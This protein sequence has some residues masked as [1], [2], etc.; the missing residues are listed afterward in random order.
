MIKVILF[1]LLTLLSLVSQ[2][3]F[4]HSIK[5]GL[6]TMKDMYPSHAENLPSGFRMAIDQYLPIDQA[7]WSKDLEEL[8]VSLFYELKYERYF[9]ELG[10]DHF[11]LAPS[12]LI[13]NWQ[14]SQNTE[15]L[16]A[17]KVTS[18]FLNFNYGLGYNGGE[19]LQYSLSIG[20]SHIPSFFREPFIYSS[21][22]GAGKSSDAYYDFYK[23]FTEDPF[24]QANSSF[25]SAFALYSRISLS[26]PM[27]DNFRLFTSL[28][29]NSNYSQTLLYHYYERK[30]LG[31]NPVYNLYLNRGAHI[32][33]QIGLAY[34]FENK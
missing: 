10:L 14:T 3:Q 28:K 25:R 32:A 8:S 19:K 21:I 27:S 26:Y 5:L 7:A 12:F 23:D 31:E 11:T 20:A 22:P 29:L 33:L 1:T 6:G 34:N 16:W 13:P 24:Q 2:A 15:M 17:S 18:G 4:S 30:E 9:L